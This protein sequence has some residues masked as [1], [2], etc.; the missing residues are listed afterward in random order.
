MRPKDYDEEITN[1]AT[2]TT[3]YTIR[4]K[5]DGHYLYHLTDENGNPQYGDD[6]Y[7]ALRFGNADEAEGSI[8]NMKQSAELEMRP[9]TLDDL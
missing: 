2:Q 9:E 6:F 1:V 8:A 3:V 7:Q 5:I 4:R